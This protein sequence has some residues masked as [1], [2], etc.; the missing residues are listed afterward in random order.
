M[1]RRANVLRVAAVVVVLGAGVVCLL[2][3]DRSAVVAFPRKL[4]PE[5]PSS[6]SL[7]FAGVGSDF[8]SVISADPSDGFRKWMANAGI[9]VDDVNWRDLNLKV[10]VRII[11]S[12]YDVLPYFIRKKYMADFAEVSGGANDI[13]L[14][15]NRELTTFEKLVKSMLNFESSNTLLPSSRGNDARASRSEGVS[16]PSVDYFRFLPHFVGRIVPGQATVSWSSRCWNKVTGKA[17]KVTDGWEVEV[18]VS[19]AKAFICSDVFPI[20]TASHVNFAIMPTPVGG[21][22]R[23]SFKFKDLTE[24][25]VWDV[26]TLGFRVFTFPTT[27]LDTVTSVLETAFLF[28]P[29]LSQGVCPLAEARNLDFLKR[30]AGINM[31]KRAQPSAQIVNETDI[32]SGDFLGIIRLDGLDPILAFGMGSHTGH[33]AIAMWE[34]GQLYIAES[35]ASG[36]YWPTNGIQRT[37]FRQWIAQAQEAGFNVVHAPLAPKYRGLFNA[38]SANAFFHANDGL[39]YGYQALFWGWIDTERHNYPCLPPWGGPVNDRVC[40]E[41]EHLE[42]LAPLIVRIIPSV[43]KEFVPAWN[44]HVTGS[45]ASGLS[46]TEIYRAATEKGLP[47]TG[48]PAVPESDSDRFSIECNNGTVVDGMAMVCDV[49]VCMMWKAGGL[50]NEIGNSFSCV[51]QTNIDV[52]ALN[53]LAPPEKR[54]AACVEADP[55][56]PLC[57]LIGKHQLTLPKLGTRKMYEHMQETCPTLPPLYERPEDC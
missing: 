28:V 21:T 51:E 5:W 46:L 12:I 9:N 32:S 47:L 55:F 52:Y 15:A 41:W 56:N 49:F 53:I 27:L 42:I 57:Q 4:L 22:K 18:S 36:N 23:Y 17:R 20:V 37:P 8:G 16:A 48:I 6:D 50:F 34:D 7:N 43:Q 29:L 11:A 3:W 14:D 24:S 45:A 31:E 25:E 33:T 10:L 44:L 13:G 19:S 1:N 38:D 40:L 26:E 30:Y 35:T 54:P 39:D 2:G